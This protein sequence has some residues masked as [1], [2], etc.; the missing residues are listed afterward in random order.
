MDFASLMSNEISKKRGSET[1]FESNKK[2]YQKRSDVEADRKAVYLA[3]QAELEARKQA[4]ILTRKQIADEAEA[5]KK[6]LEEKRKKLAEESRQRR[7][8][9][10]KEEEA[11]RRR[12]LGLPEVVEQVEVEETLDND[13]PDDELIG[14]LRAIGQPASLYG[15]SHKGRLRRWQKL[16]V[17]M[18]NGPIPTSLD[19]VEEKDM[20]VEGMP[21]DEA[22]RKYLFRQLASYFTMILKEWE[23]ALRKEPTGD[24]FA[25]KAAYSAMKRSKEDV[26]PVSCFYYCYALCILM[27][28]AVSKI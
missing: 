24:S 10:E 8:E 2:K 7:A 6:K 21:N 25:G 15:E 3:E 9:Q 18:T 12:R 20:K 16:G 28:L 27:A 17:V 22:G 19:L 26:T 5:T 13:V 14:M 11:A 4:K 1:N 23:E